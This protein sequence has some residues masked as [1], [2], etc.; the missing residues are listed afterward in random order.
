MS[1]NK[2]RRATSHERI[3]LFD[4]HDDTEPFRPVFHDHQHDPTVHA[5]QPAPTA[6]P[7]VDFAVLEREAF[8]K[9]FAQGERSGA[10]A[11]ASRT[12][13]MLRRLTGTLDDLV[14]LRSDM[15]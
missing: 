3:E 10:E 1:C 9:G 15:I 2:G 14:R 13:A 5:A 7:S 6:A 8:A 4:W 12:D 11:A